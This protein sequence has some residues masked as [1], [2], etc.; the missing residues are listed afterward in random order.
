MTSIILLI[1]YRFCCCFSKRGP[2]Y[3][4]LIH[5]EKGEDKTESDTETETE[6]ETESVAELVDE[7]VTEISA[8]K[9]R[10]SLGIE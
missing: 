2:L 8:T 7:S 6:T 3:D 1:M 4:P 10:K 9:I 5:L